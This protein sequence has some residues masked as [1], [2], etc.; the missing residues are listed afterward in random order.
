MNFY[1]FFAVA[2]VSL[3]NFNCVP[4]PIVPTNALK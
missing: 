1:S 3:T 4:V 2:L